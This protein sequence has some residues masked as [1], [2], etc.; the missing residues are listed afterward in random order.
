MLDEAMKGLPTK[1]VDEGVRLAKF[2]LYLRQ[3]LASGWKPPWKGLEVQ[4][5]DDEIRKMPTKELGVHLWATGVHARELFL[6]NRP[7]S[8]MKRL[9]V[10]YKGYAELFSRPDLWEAI[11]DGI[12]I[13][14]AQIDPDR[15]DQENLNLVMALTTLPETYGYRPIRNNLSGHE[16]EL[17]EAHIAALLRIRAFV[18]AVSGRDA[19]S[20]AAL[21]TPR[22]AIALCESALTMG[23]RLSRPQALSAQQSV[24]RFDWREGRTNEDIPRYIDQAVVELRGLV[25]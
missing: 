16:K 22:T 13:S 25:D 2:E 12:D 7:S 20:T 4:L 10:C 5:T 21:V 19:P 17:I 11:I 6:F 3:E 1:V 8:A 9:E 14:S 23:E 18:L 15:S 24:S